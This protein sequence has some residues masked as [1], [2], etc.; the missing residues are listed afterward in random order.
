ML[1]PRIYRAACLP[2]LFA[3]VLAGF[4][5]REQPRPLPASLAADAFDGAAAFRQLDRLA[6]EAPSRRPGSAGDRIV[7][8][9]VEQTLRANGFRA[10]GRGEAA[11]A[12]RRACPR[13]RRPAI[14]SWRNGSRASRSAAPP[15]VPGGEGRHACD[16]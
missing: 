11:A 8:S 5:L 1:D 12:R 16:C 3:L 4:S 14:A 7:A 2:I 13:G 15:P 6:T 10:H 9:R